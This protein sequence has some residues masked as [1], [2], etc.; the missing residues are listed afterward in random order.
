MKKTTSK[1]F[2]G[3]AGGL[4]ILGILIAVNAL[5]SGVRLRK[6]MTE[7]QLYTLSPGTV[8]LLK[9]L[10]RP[11]TLKFFYSKGNAN[12]PM[13]LK[14]YVQRTLDFLRD[15]EARSGGNIVLETWDPQPDSDA[16]EW[17]QRYGLVPQ[18]TG[19]LGVQPDLYL[20]LAAVAGTREAVIPF[21][22]PVMEPQLE[23]FLMRLVQEA[24]RER[25]SR[26]G[27]LSALP[28]L[29]EPPSPFQP[30][31]QR[32]RDWL[33]ASELKQQVDVVPIPLDAEEIPEEL[34]ALMLVHPQGISDRTLFAVDQ[35]LL[36]GGRLVAYVDPLCISAEEHLEDA[37]M[38]AL[39]SDLN[40]LTGAWGLTVQPTRV[41]ADLAMATPINLGNG[42]AER[43]PA[44]L[45]L[46]GDANL[47][48]GEILTD[49]L[50][51]VMMPFAG[52]IQGTPAEGLTMTKLAFA[53]PDAVTLNAFQA[54]NPDGFNTRTG[55]PAPEAPLAVRLTGIFPTAFPDGPPRSAGDTNETAAATNEWLRTGAQEGAVILVA[56]ADLLANEYSAQAVHLFGQTLFQPFNDNLNFTLNVAEQMSGTPELIGLRS[57]GRFDH[58][59]DRVLAMERTAQEQWQ[60]EEEKLQQKLM[61]TQQRLN[62]LQTA[63]SQDQQLVL[64]PEQKRELEAFRQERFE[65]QR[66]LKEVRK[67]LRRSIEQLGLRLKALNMAAVPLVVIAFGIG[68]GWR[69]RRRA[70]T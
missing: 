62:E 35:Y 48:R 27:I 22:D 58:P 25:R 5:F 18:A 51:S 16:E 56:D 24:T 3:V 14:N 57:R 15:V 6:D 37:G 70:A 52:M 47:A 33:F 69:R 39:S 7:E 68:F 19:G 61:Q 50:E 34:D 17:A 13:P 31:P 42:R 2:T 55:L 30:R 36:Q 67:N 4:V 45:S 43:L 32:D 54:R 29:G 12:V 28:V 21:L 65:T 11:V 41:V 60:E 8:N 53:T 49:S 10:D 40:R 9:G 46:R 23:Y 63:K 59:F 38:P 66:Q 1:L 26:V 44:W 64:S 20:G